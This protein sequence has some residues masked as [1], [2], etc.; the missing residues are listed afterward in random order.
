MIADQVSMSGAVLIK[1]VKSDLTITSVQLYCEPISGRSANFQR[2]V[3]KGQPW[4]VLTRQ[5]DFIM[6]V[7][8]GPVDPLGRLPV[9]LYRGDLFRPPPR[10]AVAYLGMETAAVTSSLAAAN[11]SESVATNCTTSLETRAKYS[12][13]ST[14]NSTGVQYAWSVTEVDSK[15]DFPFMPPE[16]CGPL[17]FDAPATI[18]GTRGSICAFI[19]C[20]DREFQAWVLDEVHGAARWVPASS[21]HAHPNQ[22]VLKGYKLNLRNPRAPSWVNSKTHRE[23]Q[24]RSKELDWWTLPPRG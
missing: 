2:V 11:V 9:T 6:R 19:S 22:T 15:T 3:H 8:A 14:I 7:I 17:H 16:P 23:Y 4:T 18:S 21:G 20:K 12:K 13:I 24:S 5:M 1:G 10:H